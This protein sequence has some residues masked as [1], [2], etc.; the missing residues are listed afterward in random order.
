MVS[1]R[2]RQSPLSKDDFGQTVAARIKKAGEPGRVTYVG[3]D[4]RI[5]IED[6][7][8]LI[9]QFNL[10][11]VYKEYCARR[12]EERE[13]MLSKIVQAALIRHK[14]PPKDWEDAK[15][16]VMP[17]VRS[18]G[19]FEMLWLEHRAPGGQKRPDLPSFGIGDHLLAV[20]VYDLPA[21]TQT[22]SDQQLDDWGVSFYEAMEVAKENLAAIQMSIAKTGDGFYA[23]L[24]GDSYDSS[25]LLLMELVQELEVRGDPIAMVPHRDVLL[26]TGSDDLDGLGL[27]SQLA[28]AAFE[29]P[30]YL[31]CLP[32]RLQGT[33]WESW[34]P[35]WDNPHFATYRLLEVKS[36]AGKY[37]R[38]A[39]L[40]NAIHAKEGTKLYVGKYRTAESNPG[41]IVS[42]C[43]WV[44]GRDTLLPKTHK[45]FLA[46]HGQGVLAG[47][48]WDRVQEVVGDLLEETDLYP[49][50]YR[51][52]GFPTPEQLTTI[53]RELR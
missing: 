14:P 52:R 10:E 37:E 50:R 38:Q 29:H 2:K 7:G 3:D 1:S 12:A 27:M 53:G 4:F 31:S 30:R 41:M 15:P 48:D 5:D 19:M 17:A 13:T 42:Y 44:Y 47:G 46:R 22:L 9:Q 39:E 34:M 45:L 20:L 8:E 18:R 24:T 49:A 23:V 28:E 11:N 25:R 33:E 21:A 40:L 36:M 6:E 26:I 51:V 35:P 16:D 32:L 43:F